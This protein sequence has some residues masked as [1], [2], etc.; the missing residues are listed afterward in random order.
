MKNVEIVKVIITTNNPAE[1]Y[2]IE[3]ERSFL[4]K[5]EHFDDCETIEEIRDKFYHECNPDFVIDFIIVNTYTNVED[6]K[7]DKL[8]EQIME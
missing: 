3:V 4:F 8:Y 2:L 7:K 6:Y 5:G 1:E